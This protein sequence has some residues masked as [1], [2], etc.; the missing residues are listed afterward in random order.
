MDEG[1]AFGPFIEH[2]GAFAGALTNPTTA[3]IVGAFALWLTN[4][5]CYLLVASLAGMSDAALAE[6]AGASSVPVFAA[7]V[8]GAVAA[9]L[10]A[11]C[12]WPVGQVAKRIGPILRRWGGRL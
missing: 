4:Y 11:W 10:Q 5:H 7:T 12:L 3:V 9:L 2:L 1:D 8:I 6:L